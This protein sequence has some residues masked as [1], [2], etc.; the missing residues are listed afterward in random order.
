MKIAIINGPNLNMLGKR[1]PAIYGT[2]TLK[3]INS[4]LNTLFPSYQ[5]IHFQSNHEGEII[6]FIQSIY[7]D[8]SIKGLVINPGAFAHYSYAIADALRDLQPK[9][10]IV[11]VHI[12]NIHARDKFRQHSV[13]AS[14]VNA[15]ICGAGSRGYQYALQ[16]VIHLAEQDD[17]PY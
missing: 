13:T 17:L 2:E 4:Q 6:D 9:K 10:P 14:C 8:E 3:D 16:E 12:S 5:L 15:V 11:E 1:N 7:F